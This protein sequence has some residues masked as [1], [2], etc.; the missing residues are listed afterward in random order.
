M[1]NVIQLR[2]GFVNLPRGGES[3]RTMAMS[4]A[5]E[6]LQFG[7]MLDSE[8]ISNL[9]S[10][11]REDL[12]K[13]HKE[14]L[15]WLKKMTG[16]NRSYVPFWKGFPEQV[17]EMSECEL[18]FHQIVHYMSNGSYEPNEWTKERPTAFENSKY[19]II[20]VGD[21]EKFLSIF[22]DLVSVNQSI[23]PDDMEVV[24]WFISSGQKLIFPESI[25]FKENLCTLAAMG[26]EV[27]VRTTTDVLRIAVSLSGG[28]ISLPRVPPSRVRANSW[29]S[30]KVDNPRREAFKF[31]KFN[32]KER[33]YILGLLERTNCD[34][35]EFVL[36]DT[37]WV[38]LGEILHPGE[39]SKQFP[40]AFG[41]F[42]AIRNGKV[43]SW[44][45]EVDR[46]FKESF[47]TGLDKISERP[48]E[49]MRRLDW[50]IRKGENGSRVLE[51]VRE[52]S[53]RISNK[54]LYEAHTHFEKR[55]TQRERSIMIKGA[56]KKTTLPDLAP[57]NASLIDEIQRGIADAL[58]VKFSKLEHLGKVWVD[59][60][61]KK[62][63]LPA[64]MRSLNSSL[65]P[66]IR[67][68]RS[69]LG[70]KD[71][72]VIRAFVHWYDEDGDRDLDLSAT[73]FGMGKVHRIAWNGSHTGSVGCHSG[74]IRHRK[75]ACAEYVDIDMGI[76]LRE[77][78]K[79]VVL[80][81]RNFNGGSLHEITD[82]VFG[83]MER[84]HP[85]SN[86]T[87]LPSTLANTVR[88]QS[89]S[90]TTIIAVLDLESREYIF[91]DIDQSGI[92]VASANIDEVLDAIKPYTELPKFSVYDLL[93]MHANARGE[94]VMNREDAN[95]K[96]RFEDFASSYIEILKWMGV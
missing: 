46:A 79:Y 55:S 72:K 22:T 75:G 84:E 45:G 18:W 51:K 61:L 68:E 15:E 8:A 76:A 90:S 27:P 19:T 52:C 38:R 67:G 57:L 58:S 60:E 3:N 43:T 23:T 83:Y 95:V 25:P 63:P 65:K 20:T 5:S 48:G 9:E 96:L 36:K 81:V 30:R 44:Y 7:Y 40:K 87:F 24:K 13:F 33:K 74:D 89:E 50:M 69:P 91:L 14:S 85:E 64:N 47:S 4:I 35:R 54:V 86:D 80:D 42:N 49:L 26:L 88:M 94:Q 1:K 92:P 82:C 32:R 70:N 21:E 6:L 16:S 66:T 11:S 39:Y 77:G 78:F 28:D 10:A 34:P 56:R 31:K 12:V 93:K 41:L 62:V 17:M 2:N 37:R 71:S 73:F 29:S 53:D 59:E